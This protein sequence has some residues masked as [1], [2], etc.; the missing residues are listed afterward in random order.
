[1]KKPNN[2][3]LN[4]CFCV[5]ALIMLSACGGGGG[6]AD[7]G[8]G[9]DVAGGGGDGNTCLFQCGDNII[10]GEDAVCDP[11]THFCATPE[12]IEIATCQTATHNCETGIRTCDN[13]E[14]FCNTPDKVSRG[15]ACD[16]RVYD[17]TGTG[18]RLACNDREKFCGTGETETLR[19][20]CEPRSHACGENNQGTGLALTC[21]DLTHFCGTTGDLRADCNP[22]SHACGENNQ[23]TGRALA[24]NDITNFC[25]TGETG[26]PRADCEPRSHACGAGNQGTGIALKC[27]DITHFCETG[28]T[29]APRATC[30]P[31][32]H[33]CGVDDHTNLPQGTGKLLACN[34]I[35]HF[36]GTGESQTP[37]ADC[38]LRSHECGTG[39]QGTGFALRCNDLTH[40][41]G[42]GETEELRAT[43]DPRSHDCGPRNPNNN[44]LFSGTGKRSD[45]N[46]YDRFCGEGESRTLRTECEP[47]SHDCGPD[48]TG[49]ALDCNDIT[50][51]CDTAEAPRTG[52]DAN[53][54][55]C[56]TGWYNP[57]TRDVVTGYL[58]PNTEQPPAGGW[59]AA[60]RTARGGDYHASGGADRI[61]AAYAH[62]RG[63]SGIIKGTSNSVTVSIVGEGK[64]DRYHK[65]LSAQLVAGYV[66]TNENSDPNAGTCTGIGSYLDAHLY[67]KEAC[68]AVSSN[69]FILEKRKQS[70]HIAGIIAGRSGNGGIQG[71]AYNAKIKPINISIDTD[72]ATIR[73]AE[74]ARDVAGSARI[75]HTWGTP[76]RVAAED[77][78]RAANQA[79]YDAYEPT[80]EKRAK[81]IAQASGEDIAVMLNNWHI[82]YTREVRKSGLYYRL[83][84]SLTTSTLR[85]SLERLSASEI[86]AWKK[87][88]ETTVLVFAAGDYGHNNE[89]GLPKTYTDSTLSTRSYSPAGY[90]THSNNGSGSFSYPHYDIPELRG[91]LL[92]VIALDSNNTIY[93]Y[94]SGCG[95]TKDFCL[96]APGV[97]IN[98]TTIG[99]SY[100]SHSTYVE[101]SGTAQAAAHVAGA[102]AVLKGAFPHLTPTQLVSIILDSADYIPL[103]ENELGE[104]SN[105]VYGRGALNLARAS[106]PLG[107]MYMVAP[108]GTA[109]GADASLDNSGITIPTSF[110]GALTDL[111]VGFMDDYDR[112]F[113]GFPTRIAQQ[114]IAFTLDETMATWDSP[115]LQSITLDSN[116]KMQFTNYDESEDAKDTLMF[117]HSLPNH[118][119]GFSYNEE[120]KTPD[121]NLANAGE[122]LHFQKILPIAK[123]LMQ[124]NSTYKLG[125]NLTV[126]NAITSGEFD[127]GN[128]FNEAMTNLNYAG[129]NRNLTIGAGT[130]KE[131]GQFLGASGTG[132]YQLSDATSSQVTHLAVT[133]N[134]P[135][136]SAIK[137]KYT[138][139]KTEVDMR[140]DNFAKINDLTANE[141][142]LSLTKKQLFGK[143]DSLNLE[144]IQPFAVT[145]GKLQQNTVLGYT[146]DGNYNNVT[147]NY[148]LA[149]ANRRQQLRMTWQNQINH[150]RKTKLFISMQ[151]ENHVDNVRDN[152]DSQILGGIS[153]RF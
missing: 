112:A 79:V 19:E 93:K 135:R 43:C 148:T 75:M 76:E 78:Y 54:Y 100:S 136:N 140:Y 97:D 122:E 64:V 137:L 8:T 106:E 120:Q 47:R 103:K 141:Y 114:N 61:G 51:F 67:Y 36:C 3:L 53:I 90:I 6:A 41:C 59:N 119:I 18:D 60:L 133:Q 144:L 87:A 80:R 38:N 32:S 110:G 63:Y 39:N 1:M 101:Q 150:E 153:T 146:A 116:S 27:N 17:C 102:V 74:A 82:E 147:Q 55:N 46:D 132:A 127:T 92:N 138:G 86:T 72:T 33:A 142:Q 143:N 56:T 50:H 70:T 89:N 40:F 105:V 21:N 16:A 109:L 31:R 149:P 125:K 152:N 9:E 48:A 30:N 11:E 4:L 94:S 128:R 37:R 126:K 139:F 71:I 68:R 113:I 131:Y 62:A 107:E 57:G 81:A 91:K 7:D 52:C 29:E 117:T 20:L 5:F 96:G 66:A 129:E 65:D 58:P 121:L 35:T 42:T 77:A 49:L 15:A 2:I 22:A 151:Y 24:C 123:D 69:A 34:D 115:E 26:E 25:G 108:S 134:L 85:Y 130:L 83:R 13:T 28:E 14:R 95:N 99:P 84:H 104:D 73:N 10:G 44:N 12:K 88:A 145:D 124:L 98:S 111:T 118:T 45:C 23:G